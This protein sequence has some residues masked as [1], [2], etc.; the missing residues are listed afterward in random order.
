QLRCL[1]N[2][3]FYFSFNATV[4][5][6]TF[7]GAVVSN[8]TGFAV[9]D[10][11]NALAFY[12]VLVDQNV[13]NS[14]STALGQT[15]VVLVSTYGVGMTFYSGA[16]LRV[17]LHE[18]SQVLDVAVAFFTN[19]GLVEVELHVQLNADQFWLRLWLGVN[20]RS[21]CWLW[22]RLDLSNLTGAA[23]EVHTNTQTCHPLAF[24]G[25]DV[26]HA[27]NAGF[28][29]KVLCEVVL[30]TSADVCKGSAVTTTTV[31]LT[32]ALM[33]STSG[34]VGTQTNSRLTEVVSGVQGSQ[35][36]LD[37]LVTI[38]AQ[39]ILG[40]QVMVFAV[41]QTERNVFGQ[42]VTDASAIQLTVAL[43]ITRAVSEIV[44]A[45]RFHLYGALALSQRANRSGGNQG[46]N[47]NAQGVFKLHP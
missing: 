30:H 27:I 9:T 14:L 34:N 5:L 13:A 15:L 24:V 32:D 20:D 25:I 22:S 18:V 21:R 11:V 45:K 10:G 12:A 43:Y 19:L 3:S 38:S 16:G 35:A 42:K 6:A 44:L 4:D 28:G 47:R 7:F 39:R 46:A 2:L 8:R 37:V 17:L 41:G 33:G 31:C 36:A 1:A 40:S 26:V 29:E 23:A